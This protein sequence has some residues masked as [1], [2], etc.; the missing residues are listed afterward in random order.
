MESLGHELGRA[1]VVYN[2]STYYSHSNTFYN[3]NNYYR[4]GG[5]RGVTNN[6]NR[7]VN[8]DNHTNT[9]GHNGAGRTTC[10]GNV[11]NHPGASP[12]PV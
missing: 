10:R 5:Y 1:H 2:H 12:R 4:N 7:G 6:V 8:G 11:Y 9:L 3:R